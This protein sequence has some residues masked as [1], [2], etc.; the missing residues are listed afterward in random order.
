[1]IAARVG[2]A[3]TVPC[4]KCNAPEFTPCRRRSTLDGPH[5]ER[6]SRAPAEVFI[7]V[8][9]LILV[10]SSSPS[11]SALAELVEIRGGMA[12]IRRWSERG[13]RWKLPRLRPLRDVIGVA[14]SDERTQRAWEARETTEGETR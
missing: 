9:D 12:L 11:R 4:P 2:G 10:R 3:T 7:R 1:M 13:H 8:G 6:V 14:P 5:K